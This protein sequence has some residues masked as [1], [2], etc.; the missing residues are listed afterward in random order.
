MTQLFQTLWTSKIG[1]K[2]VIAAFASESAEDLIFIKELVEAGKIKAV[3]D[4]TYPM[5][6]IVDAHRYVEEGHKKGNV[7]ITV[8][9][10]DKT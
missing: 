3:I 4:R 1:S 2:K 6:Q 10:N 5:E 7:V 8:G 9:H